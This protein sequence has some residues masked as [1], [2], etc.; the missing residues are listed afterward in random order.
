MKFQ[1]INSRFVL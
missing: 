1:L